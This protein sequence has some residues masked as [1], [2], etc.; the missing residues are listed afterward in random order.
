MRDFLLRCVQLLTPRFMQR[1]PLVLYPPV[2][3]L[4]PR[5]S[6]SQT[7]C[8]ILQDDRTI[9]ELNVS[10]PSTYLDIAYGL[11]LGIY[12]RRFSLHS[13]NASLVCR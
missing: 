13:S 11:N 8:A 6:A 3:I 10:L 7:P 1:L 5:C 2:C 4:G 9:P 12:P